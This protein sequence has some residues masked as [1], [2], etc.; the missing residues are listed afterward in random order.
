M[1]ACERRGES[2]I[3][4]GKAT[5]AGRP[6]KR[7]LHHPAPWQEDKTALGFLE[8]D[9]FQAYSVGGGLRR[10]LLSGVALVDKGYFNGAS[11]HGLNLPRQVCDLRALL[12]IGRRNLQ[13]QEMSQCIDCDMHFA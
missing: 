8:L 1:K 7:P 12:L 9:D 2:F 6:S 4:A 3:V 5:K 10:G 13:G 11:G